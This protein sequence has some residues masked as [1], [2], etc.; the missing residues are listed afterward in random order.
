MPDAEF[1]GEAGEASEASDRGAVADE[2]GPIV[3]DDVL[4]DAVDL[5]RGALL[6]VTAAQSVGSVV[7]H[8]A[9]GEHVLSLHFAADL[10]GYPG[11]HWSVTLARVEGADPTVLETELLPGEQA[12]LAPEWVPWSDRL[13]EYRAAQA[14]AAA[15]A[16]SAEGDDEDDADADEELDRDRGSDGDEELDADGEGDADEG[17]DEFGEEDAGD[18]LFDGI[19]IDALDASDDEGADD[20]GADDED[21]D[22]EGDADAAGEAD[23]DD[24]ERPDGSA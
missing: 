16:E 12:L 14:A 15:E 21:D 17:D 5:A 19:D 7:G 2:V 8:V 18:D 1:P 20:E 23:A 9:E 6:E 3:A 11:W 10:P 22:D 24:R 4:L 13:A